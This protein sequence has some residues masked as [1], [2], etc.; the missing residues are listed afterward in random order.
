MEY[1]IPTFISGSLNLNQHKGDSIPGIIVVLLLAVLF[2]FYGTE[3]NA[4]SMSVCRNPKVFESANINNYVKEFSG[5]TQFELPEIAAK[6]GHMLAHLVQLDGLYSQIGYGPVGYVFVRTDLEGPHECANENIINGVERRLKKGHGYSLLS[7]HFEQINEEVYLLTTISFG[8]KYIEELIKFTYEVDANILAEFEAKLPNTKISFSPRHFTQEQ[9]LGVL[10]EYQKHMNIWRNPGDSTP[11][12]NIDPSEL[13]EFAYS[14]EEVQPQWFKIR[15]Y[16]G[17]LPS[18]WMQIPEKIGKLGLRDLV[19]ELYFMDAVAMYAQIRVN[20]DDELYMHRLLRFEELLAE[21]TEHSQ[22][23]GDRH[24]LG[25]LK[26]MH[27]ALLA[28]NPD[29]ASAEASDRIAGISRE[30]AELVPTN[31][32]ITTLAA[33]A[34]FLKASRESE[35]TRTRALAQLEKGLLTLLSTDPG[36][37]YIKANLER[38]WRLPR[39]N[40]SWETNSIKS[41][42]QRFS[43]N[44][45]VQALLN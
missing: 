23:V 10:H 44:A 35:Q 4:A 25:I 11:L 7:G 34:E 30:A 33:L 16:T 38:V 14:I 37:D 18:G 40:E 45:D 13:Q 21:F 22:G 43:E 19:P 6:T 17:A 42:R 24:A 29:G 1:K 36:N 39:S 28:E 5:V 20:P 8:R 26:S 3:V 15:S 27:V 32:D 12:H 31:R 41:L 2:V 9:L